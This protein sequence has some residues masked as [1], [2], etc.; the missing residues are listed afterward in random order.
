MVNVQQEMMAADISGVRITQYLQQIVYFLSL[1]YEEKNILSWFT[2][3]WQRCLNLM[4][5]LDFMNWSL[6]YYHWFC[7]IILYIVIF[8]RSNMSLL[9]P[10]SQKNL[11]SWQD[12]FFRYGCKEKIMAMKMPRLSFSPK[13]LG[14]ALRVSFLYRPILSDWDYLIWLRLKKYRE[15]QILK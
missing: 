4:T 12:F 1:L 13:F 6:V 5:K 8:V 10:F 3:A 2:T 15:K 11:Q 14:H 7:F 9:G